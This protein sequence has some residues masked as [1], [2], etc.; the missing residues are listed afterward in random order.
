VLISKKHIYKFTE[1]TSVFIKNIPRDIS[2]TQLGEAFQQFGTVL[3]CQVLRDHAQ[4]SKEMGLVNFAR[5]EF[6]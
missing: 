5:P 2:D 3:N 6:M 1:N 4:N